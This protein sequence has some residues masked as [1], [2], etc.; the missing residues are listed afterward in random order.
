MSPRLRSGVIY[1]NIGI[2]VSISIK[3]W[4]TMKS[5]IKSI[6]LA[7]V[8]AVCAMAVCSCDKT[9][10][11][12]EVVGAYFNQLQKG[13]LKKAYS[14][15]CWDKKEVEETIE[16]L[17]GLNIRIKDFE[18]LSEVIADDGESAVVNVRYTY[19]YAFDNSETMEDTV[20]EEINLILIDGQWKIS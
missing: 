12:S 6:G 7:L 14:Y 2:A 11:P 15:T 20:E 13:H 5:I 3:Y 4:S 19:V 8:I 17:E 9:M 1:P 10:T 16:K 18:T